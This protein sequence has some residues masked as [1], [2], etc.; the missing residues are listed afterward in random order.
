MARIALDEPLALPSIEAP[1]GWA[2]WPDDRVTCESCANRSGFKC[3]PLRCSTHILTLK[4]RC[5]KHAKR[6][7]RT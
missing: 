1:E 7:G 5:E 3:I 6:Q 2:D 4:H